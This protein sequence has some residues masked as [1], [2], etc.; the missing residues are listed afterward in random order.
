MMLLEY[1]TNVKDRLIATLIVCACHILFIQCDRCFKIYNGCCSK[2]CKNF[3][4]L[5]IEEQ[6]KLRKDPNRV[7]SL[8]RYS[9]RVKPKLKEITS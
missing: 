2:E 9:S 5:P 3:A 1:V 7:V 4:S 8:S 6:K